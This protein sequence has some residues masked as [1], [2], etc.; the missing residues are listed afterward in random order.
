VPYVLATLPQILQ[1]PWLAVSAR[2][3]ISLVLSAALALCVAYSIWYT[4]VQ[5]LGPARTSIYSNL[6]PIVAIGFAALWLGE[7]ITRVKMAG[8]AA[9]LTGVAL[10][11]LGRRPTGAAPPEE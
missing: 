11:R 4:G 1:V 10:T 5:K 3:W 6:V 8:V 7:P 9:V 2:V